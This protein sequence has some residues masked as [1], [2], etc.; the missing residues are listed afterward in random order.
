MKILV[1]DY[2]DG[3]CNYVW[4]NVDKGTPFYSGNYVTVD[5][6]KY[7]PL[8][9]IRIKG[10]FRKSKCD[11]VVC[12]NCGQM[13]KRSEVEKH[14]IEKES[15]A[16]CIKCN[17][18]YLEE[19]RDERKNR[20]LSNGLILSRTINVP[21]CK[22]GYYRR[23]LLSEIDRVSECK[24]FA[25]RR[26]GIREL[27]RDYLYDYPNLYKN[28]LTE[29]KILMMGWKYVTKNSNGRQYSNKDGHLIAYF[30]LNGILINFKLLNRNNGYTFVYSDVYDKFFERYSEFDFSD[31][32]AER[33]KERYMKTIRELYK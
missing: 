30:D 3:T 14:Y 7:P 6:K 12:K 13:I 31:I 1:R 32:V 33:T 9:I 28:L 22:T 18:L 2:A 15:D 20:L 25:C 24:Y 10:D 17:E 26:S 16:N 8:D 27:Y 5:N 21:Y 11:Y 29:K 19:K 4:K 23:K